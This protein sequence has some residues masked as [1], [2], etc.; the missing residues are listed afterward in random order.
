MK[1]TPKLITECCPTCRRD[2]WQRR[3]NFSLWTEEEAGSLTRGRVPGA[4]ENAEQCIV[5]SGAHV[6]SAVTEGIGL[7]K[8]LGKPVAFLFND[9]PIILHADSD[10]EEALRRWLGARRAYVADLI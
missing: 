9:T 2:G 1:R 8:M 3:E 7:A 4:P 5:V 10:A 6:S